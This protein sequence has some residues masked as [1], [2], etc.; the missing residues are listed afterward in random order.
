M[1]SEASVLSLLKRCDS[2]T[3]QISKKKLARIGVVVFGEH[4]EPTKAARVALCSS[5]DFFSSA[6]TPNPRINAGRCL[7]KQINIV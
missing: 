2:Y 1:L 6:L 7:H 3:Q 5:L 4:V